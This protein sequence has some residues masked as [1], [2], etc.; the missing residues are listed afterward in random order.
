MIQKL[1]S[2][3]PA[4]SVW[5]NNVRSADALS[6]RPRPPRV[7]PHL[8][9]QRMQVARFALDSATLPLATLALPLAEEVRRRLIATHARQTAR[10]L[11]GPA[12]DYERFR[13]GELPVPLSPVFAGKD[14]AGARRTDNHRHAY[15]LLTDEDGDGRLDHLTVSSEEGFALDELQ[16]LHSL[17][18]L[19]STTKDGRH[20][21][22]LVLL[23]LGTLAELL[24]RVLGPARTWVS[25]TPYLCTRFPK[26]RGRHRQPH[27]GLRQPHHFALQDLQEEVLRWLQRR[28][29][30]ASILNIEPLTDPNGAFTLRPQ[31]WCRRSSGPSLRPIQYK[32]F[33]RKASDDGGRRLTGAFRLIFD[34]P[35]TGP[36]ALGH[37][38]HFSL[39]LFLPAVD[40]K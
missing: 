35:V 19:T 9:R 31:S 13:A 22:R 14:G 12:F 30:H 27:E 21:V 1:G 34:Q 28:H 18:R 33:R 29:P 6:L 10:R 20:P 40:D 17:H 36:L 11:Y 26:S 37:S 8:R 3:D 4:G 16:A 23:G 24:P 15:Y 32:R 39:G 2:F 5:I 7:P 25:A 38:C